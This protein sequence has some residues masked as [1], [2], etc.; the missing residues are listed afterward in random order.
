MTAL[1]EKIAQ[2]PGMR[3]TEL[4][5]LWR[6]VWRQPAPNLG[7]DLLRRGIA[8]KL[9]ARVHGDLPSSVRRDI[10]R[11]LARLRSGEALAPPRP[12]LRPGT[13]LI[14]QWN[15][16]TYQVVVLDQGFEHA[17][18]RYRS[19]TEVARAITGTHQSGLR[20]FGV[21]ARKRAA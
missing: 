10:D 18:K 19:L 16:T 14:R 2:L 21:T 3:P 13:R 4:R 7:P 1:E 20:F 5:A 6:E 11:V 17:G 8:W 15:G 12:S 9:Q